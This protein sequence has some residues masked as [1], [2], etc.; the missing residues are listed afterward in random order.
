MF[1]EMLRDQATV[2]IRRSAGGE[3]DDDIDPFTF[4]K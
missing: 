2:G 3:A 1:A 4:I